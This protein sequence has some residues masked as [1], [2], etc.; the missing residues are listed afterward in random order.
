MKKKIKEYSPDFKLKVVMEYIRGESNQT[1]FS[2]KYGMPT[3]TIRCWISHFLDNVKNVFAE[4]RKDKEF[5]ES[6]R[7]KD[8]QIEELHKTV[9]ELTVENNWIKKNI[10]NLGFHFRK[11]MI[12]RGNEDLS[13]TTQCKILNISRSCIYYKP[14]EPDKTTEKALIK[15]IRNIYDEACFYG[16]IKIW[17]VLERLGYK[18]VQ[19]KVRKLREELE[20]KAVCPMYS[21]Y[22]NRKCDN[23]F[24]YLL[25]RIIVTRPN[26]VW[27]SDIT[28][29]P[30]SE[31]YVYKT[32]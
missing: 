6:I 10:E 17:K 8:K 22:K 32:L 7:S 9:G 12:I 14:K 28:Y 15:E 25:D 4:K 29:V 31:G 16:H 19:K 13:I 11:N 24:P 30:T 3:Y 20:L 26:Q 27:Q 2:Q 5:K 18:V 1:E 21:R 23:K